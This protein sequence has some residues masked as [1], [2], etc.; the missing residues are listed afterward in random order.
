MTEVPVVIANDLTEE[1]EKALR[2]ADNK[3]SELAEW[4]FNLLDKELAELDIDMSQFGFINEDIGADGF[5]ED[6]SISDQETPLTRTITLSLNEEQYDIA[7]RVIDYVEEN[8][9]IMHDFGNHNKKSN[10]LFEGVYQWAEQK[11]LL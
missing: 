3:T 11:K 7:M 2:L 8:G 4:D 5:G 6:F 9:L 10:A 1:Q